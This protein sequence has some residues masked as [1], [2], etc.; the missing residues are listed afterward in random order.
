ML[1]LTV[2]PARPASSLSLGALGLGG[3][4][5]Q[6]HSPFTVTPD[7]TLFIHLVFAF[8]AAR[9]VKLPAL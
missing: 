2:S 3:M 1:T 7:C 5:G 6:T 8:K 4:V 9:C